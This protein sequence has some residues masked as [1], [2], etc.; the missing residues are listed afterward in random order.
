MSKLKYTAS[1]RAANCVA[2][3]EGAAYQAAMKPRGTLG[4]IC[5]TFGLNYNTA[6]LQVN[7]KRTCHTL[8][9]SLIEQ[10]LSASPNAGLIM[11]AICCAHGRAGWFLLPDPNIECDAMLDI[12]MLGKKFADLNSTAI[13][14]WED[15]IIEPD[16]YASIQ[17]DCQALLRHIQTIREK[18]RINME[19]NNVR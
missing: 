13:E 4:A 10:L 9:P 2:D 12:A 18:A 6:A 11:D 1:E 8:P 17:K 3:L 7:P 15:K 16:E 19:K 14:A 5:E